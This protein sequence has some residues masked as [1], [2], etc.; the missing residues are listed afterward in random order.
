MIA[1][2]LTPA[3]GCRTGPQTARK[4]RRRPVPLEGSDV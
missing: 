3:A 1:I 2:T 4:V